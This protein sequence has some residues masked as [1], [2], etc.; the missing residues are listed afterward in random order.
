M[1]KKMKKI[2]KSWKEYLFKPEEPEE[3]LNEVVIKT[4]EELIDFITR[5]PNQEMFIDTPAGNAK[6]F[7]GVSKRTLPF[8]YGEYPKLIN[9]ADNMGW[10][11]AIVPSSSKRGT[12]ML[13]VGY[14]Q[15]HDSDEVW[16]KVGKEK[17][18]NI[19]ANTKII[20]ANDGIYSTEDKEIVNIFF[21][22][23]LQFKPVVWFKKEERES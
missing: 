4:K 2:F 11:I 12:N 18:D 9:P 20:L 23:I 7:G 1:K 14:A 15:Y 21:A 17:P 19:S 8:D 22:N 3:I 16:N 6:K 13:P 5:S 10:D